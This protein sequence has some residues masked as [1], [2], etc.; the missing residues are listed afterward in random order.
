MLSKRPL[1]YLSL[2]SLAL[3]IGLVWFR[4]K[5]SILNCDT[6]G[7]KKARTSGGQTTTANGHHSGSDLNRSRSSAV[8]INCSEG[9]DE[10]PLNNSNSSGNS[11]SS[12]KSAPI[13]IQPNS[14][15]P[16]IPI[17]NGNNKGGGNLDLNELNS[18]IR[19]S[20]YRTLDSIDESDIE[21]LS[22]SPVD[23]PGSYERR[24]FEFVKNNS[25]YKRNK[26]MAEEPVI[27]TATKSPKISPKNAF[28]EVGNSSSSEVVSAVD[29]GAEVVIVAATKSGDKRT[30]TASDLVREIIVSLRFY[31]PP[32]LLTKE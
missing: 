16:P 6:G 11:T 5:K 15:S 17:K 4:R 24:N 29:N 14:R 8:N 3:L 21:S 31:F 18:K 27:I 30:T 20:E 25:F 19:D 1:L 12:S 2:P 26:K 10:E 9:S 28:S 7:D 23:L 32:K 22:I 13:D